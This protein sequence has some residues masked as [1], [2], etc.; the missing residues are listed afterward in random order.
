LPDKEYLKKTVK[1][2]GARAKKYGSSLEIF[3]LD[4]QQNSVLAYG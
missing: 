2:K 3:A 4:L 1:K